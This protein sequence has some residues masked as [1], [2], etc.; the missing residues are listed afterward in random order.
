MKFVNIFTGEVRETDHVNLHRRC[1]WSTDQLTKKGV[2]DARQS[3]SFYGI[4]LTHYN[5]ELP[6][7]ERFLN[8][9][10][11]G[12]WCQLSDELEQR[13]TELRNK[14]NSLEDAVKRAKCELYEH[15]LKDP[16][17]FNPK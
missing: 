10:V 11:S 9:Y 5:K 1:F 4:G 12:H 14:I 17:N 8:G 16:T 2:P 13:G 7:G 3:P 15:Y 6:V